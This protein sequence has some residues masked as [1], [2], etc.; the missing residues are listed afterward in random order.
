MGN[1]D[2]RYRIEAEDATRRGVNSALG[3]FGRLRRGV[4]SAFR[5]MGR[6]MRSARLWVAGFAA[7]IGYMVR[8]SIQASTTTAKLDQ[9][10]KATGQSAGFTT[11]Q[12]IE[13]AKALEDMTDINRRNIEYAQALLLTFKDIKGDV[14]R[15]AVQSGLD[16]AATLKEGTPAAEDLRSSFIML[17]KAL[18]DPLR[19]MTA[20]R[21][22]G[23]SFTKAEE[24]MVKQLME[25][26]QVTKAQGVI[27]DALRGQFGG[28][29]AAIAQADFGVGKLQNS[30]TN[31]IRKG[32]DAILRNTQLK[33]GFKELSERIDEFAESDKFDQWSA[34]AGKAIDSVKDRIDKFMA[35]GEQR[36]LVLAEVRDIGQTV[37]DS[38]SAFLINKGPDIGA[39]I[40]KGFVLAAKTGAMAGVGAVQ[41]RAES[42]VNFIVQDL[43]RAGASPEIQERTRQFFSLR[44]NEARIVE[45]L[46]GLR[47]DLAISN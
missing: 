36:E 12:L 40:A 31:L 33:G 42:A 17:G 3:N 13:Q 18:N 30:W 9:I 2:L 6:V 23:V 41:G 14:F 25:T 29:A 43:Q 24:D 37:G 4:T 10:V 39:A 21:R 11:K 27:L 28:V 45:E 7:S 1:D 16:M 34:R 46:K 26:N 19:G 20:M 15:E 44:E 35:G 32:G 22:V 47:R 8:S 38:A 5:S